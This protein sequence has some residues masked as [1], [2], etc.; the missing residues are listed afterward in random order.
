MMIQ[1]VIILC[2]VILFIKEAHFNH[3]AHTI[4]NVKESQRFAESCIK[5]AICPKCCRIAAQWRK[6]ELTCPT[7]CDVGCHERNWWGA[8][9]MVYDSDEVKKRCKTC[10]CT[11]RGVY[12]KQ[13]IILEIR[14]YLQA[15]DP[16]IFISPAPKLSIIYPTY[17]VNMF[18]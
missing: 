7:G 10:F 17:T 3:T 12:S 4:Q 13:N 5:H 18:G 16:T 15:L 6:Q 9:W 1:C 14:K 8:L 2:L 11:Y